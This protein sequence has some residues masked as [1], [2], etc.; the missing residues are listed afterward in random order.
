MPLSPRDDLHLDPELLALLALGER[1]GTPEAAVANEHHLAGCGICTS[2][3]DEL[4]TVVRSARLVTPDDALVA[5]PES[6][7]ADIQ[8]D[9]AAVPEPSAVVALDERRRRRTRFLGLAAA[10]CLGLVVGG[11]GVYAVTS[12][13]DASTTPQVLASAALDPL[14]GQTATGTVT[15]VSTSSGPQVSVDV[16]GLAKPDGF[17]EVWLLDKDA[18]K[19]IALGVLDGTDKGVF[20]MPPGVSMSDYPVVD[21]SLEPQDGNP[22][23]SHNSL[24][25]GIL[26]A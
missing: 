8:A 9:L 14:E 12:G 1:P 13:D 24:V 22:E 5:P 3:L 18:K 16:S 26:P 19:L 23:H 25:R 15:V 4:A 20:A 7:W 2:E 17:Y 11:G 10:A 6:V 21:V